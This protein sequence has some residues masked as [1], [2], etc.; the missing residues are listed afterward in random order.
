MLPN[1]PRVSVHSEVAALLEVAGLL[2]RI[3]HPQV[4]QEHLQYLDNLQP[5]AQLGGLAQEFLP[6]I[7]QQLRGLGPQQVCSFLYDCLFLGLILSAGGTQGTTAPVTTG[8]SNPPFQP[9][10]EKETGNNGP[11]N[12]QYQAISCMPAY[13]G[14]SHEVCFLSSWTF[15]SSEPHLIGNL[16]NTIPRLPSGP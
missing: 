9:Y 10:T 12:I 1:L 6:P 14:T 13:Q 7:S 8:S 11:V 3:T 16:G 5:L 4:D 15:H 2:D